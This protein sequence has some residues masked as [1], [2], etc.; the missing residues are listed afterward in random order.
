M[1]EQVP[2]SIEEVRALSVFH[3]MIGLE[4]HPTWC[5]CQQLCGGDQ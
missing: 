3:C 2:I 4:G 5:R 1:D